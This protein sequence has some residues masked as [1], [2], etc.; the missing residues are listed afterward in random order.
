[1]IQR[2]SFQHDGSVK[3]LK[4]AFGRWCEYGEV[5]A[6][7][8][9]AEERCRRDGAQAMYLFMEKNKVWLP[10]EKTAIKQALA[11]LPPVGGAK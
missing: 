10:S 3:R 6:A 9:E 2:W 11:T 8:R 1:M 4:T 7:I 5:E